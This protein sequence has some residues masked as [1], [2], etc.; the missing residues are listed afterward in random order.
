MLLVHGGELELLKSE[1][2][3]QQKIA[4]DC[5]VC[6][7]QAY[8]RHYGVIS[9]YA[10]KMFFRRVHVGKIVY[11]CRLT[12]N[13]FK[14]MEQQPWKC[15]SCRYQRCL[16]VGMKYT[17]SEETLPFGFDESKFH[18]LEALLKSLNTKDNERQRKLG[19]FYS[20]NDPSLED[21]VMHPRTV[22]YFEKHPNHQITPEEWAFLALFSHMKYFMSFGFVKELSKE[23][24][25]AIFKHCTLKLTY[26]CGLMRTLNERRMKML[27]P[28]GQEIYPDDLILHYRNTPHNLLRICSEPVE[29]MIQWDVSNEEYCLLNLIFFC[30]PA[31]PEISENAKLVLA[32]H[33][34][35]YATALLHYC[36][37]NHQK[38]APTRLADLYSLFGIITVN[39]K[40]MED[41]FHIFHCST[42][43]QFKKLVRDTFHF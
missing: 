27:S 39:S 10:C 42:S 41:L 7:R 14:I 32:S 12:N 16:N 8:G 15:Q 18:E 19:S 22:K 21:I 38:N 36:Q 20:V 28:G 29:K 26:F 37:I 5:K 40:K 2:E 6:G 4:E 25:I 33:Q 13:C 35:K 9:C 11:T 1:P 17:P 24:Q 31:T 3:E 34:Q 23:D 43:F 30:N